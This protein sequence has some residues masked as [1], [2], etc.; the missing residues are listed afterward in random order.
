MVTFIFAISFILHIITIFAI[1]LLFK[2]NQQL[3]H[4]NIH[5]TTALLESYLAEIKD[6]NNR[7]QAELAVS[8][9]NHET[10]E[11]SGV[12]KHHASEETLIND[13]PFSLRDVEQTDHVEASL[14]AKVLQLHDQ[15]FTE[16]EIAKKLNC[17]K[18]EAAL[19][20]KLH[21]T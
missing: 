16:T 11:A 2:Q 5:D 18:T 12:T 10:D 8:S 15:G 20:I 21:T 17:G 4:E 14:Q 3:K 13:D 19:I 6:E 7:L 1:Y 9:S